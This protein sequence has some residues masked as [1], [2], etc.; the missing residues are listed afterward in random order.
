MW[1]NG[2]G[3]GWGTA[4]ALTI[5]LLAGCYHGGTPPQLC[6]GDA[7]GLTSSSSAATGSTGVPT[8][9]EPPAETTVDPTT[10]APVDDSVTFRLDT[11]SFMDP[12]LFYSSPDQTLCI[13]DVT[14]FVNVALNDDAMSGA[15]NLLARFE[16]FE[17]VNEMRLIDAECGDPVMPGGR[18]LCT[19]K[20][21]SQAV[22]LSSMRI[23]A[24]ACTD[25]DLSKYQPINAP[26]IHAPQLP[27]L[28][29]N[30]VD[31]SLPINNSVGALNLREAQVSASLD[32]L[33]DPQRLEDGLL[34]GFLTK[35]V[36]EDLIFTDTMIGS[37]NIWAMVDSPACQANFP[38]YLPSIDEFEI[39]N[40]LVP[41]VWIA[42][43]FTAERVDYQPL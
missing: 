10:G 3:P 11:L 39:N 31:F 1:T 33:S 32:A 8:T 5:A 2:Q 27:C 34:F 17:G 29:S 12:H 43:N 36:A 21:K 18:R 28:R 13:N 4:A 15:F 37:V 20:P 14:D 22:L 35:A 23:E 19:P 38:D 16:D 25:I 41:G 7:C 6:Q 30:Q 9:G 24:G 42:L 40:T 26:A